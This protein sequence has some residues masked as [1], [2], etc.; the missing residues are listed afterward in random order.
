MRSVSFFLI[1]LI[2]FSCSLNKKPKFRRYLAQPKEL[3]RYVYFNTE[4]E[5]HLSFP[6]LF[7]PTV[8][9]R[10]GI[11]GVVRKQFVIDSSE[12][13]RQVELRDTWHFRFFRS[14]PASIEIRHYYDRQLIGRRKINYTRQYDVSGYN[15]ASIERDST[16][17]SENELIEWGFQLYEIVEKTSHVQKFTDKSSGRNLF[18]VPS[19]SYWGPL[20]VD[21][22]CSPHRKDRIVLG[23]P[24]KPIRIYSVENKVEENSVTQFFYHPS[25]G[26]IE[27]IETNDFPF[28]ITRTYIYDKSGYCK[29][30]IDSTFSS[31]EFLLR[32]VSNIRLNH[33]KLPVLITH[34]KET[35]FRKLG[36]TSYEKFIYEK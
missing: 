24:K 28:K 36:V 32:T 7:D 25:N 15:Q 30:Y 34:R 29:S 19:K 26:R 9:N 20:S 3:I 35:S 1:V 23:T 31:K 17:V 8:I 27:R 13:G 12:D 33:E 21:S 11:L 5:K 16:K 10:H 2:C 14:H 6:L 4:F 18:F 22:L